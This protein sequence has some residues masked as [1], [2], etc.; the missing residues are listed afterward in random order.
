MYT[1]EVNLKQTPM[2]L[3]VQKKTLEDA[4]ADYRRLSEAIAGSSGGVLELTCDQMPEKRITLLASEVVAIQIYEKSGTASSSGKA[5][6]F[7]SL[8]GGDEGSR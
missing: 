5:P 8:V 6:G 4:Q 2:P 3:S 7:F 1:L